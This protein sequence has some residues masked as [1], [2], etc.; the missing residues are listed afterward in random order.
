MQIKVVD[1]DNKMKVPAELIEISDKTLAIK[2]PYNQSIL[3][4]IKGLEGRKWDKE[5]KMWSFMH[6]NISQRNQF[7]LSVMTMG[8]L[9]PELYNRYFAPEPVWELT[10]DLPL[11]AHQVKMVKHVLRYRRCGL[12]AEMGTGKTLAIIQAMLL[13]A[14]TSGLKVTPS[15][16][17]VVGPLVA[18]RAWRQEIKKWG[19]QNEFTPQLIHSHH[20]DLERALT[21]AKY[22]PLFVNIDESSRI[23]TP[24]AKRT[25]LVRE[26]S[27]LSWL[28]WKNQ[29]YFVP[30]TG[31]VAPKDP[32]DWYMQ[33]EIARPGWYQENTIHG[34]RERLANMS[35]FE[36]PHGNYKKVDS[37]KRSEVEA[38][39]KRTKIFLVVLKKD[40]LDLPEKVYR[41]II[42][43]VTPEYKRVA[44][45][46]K[47]SGERAITVLQQLRQLSDGFQYTESG[48]DLMPKN[49]KLDALMEF[50]DEYEDQEK[51][52]LVVYSGYTA[53]VDLLRH[54]YTKRGWHVIQVDGRGWNAYSANGSDFKLQATLDQFQS[55]NLDEKICFIANADAGG[56]GI[57]LTQSDTIV[58]Y[59]NSF[60]AESRI[61]SEDRIHRIGMKGANIVDLFHLPTD[62]QVWKLLKLKRSLQSLTL[63]EI[64]DI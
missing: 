8:Q 40:C 30:M 20:V 27:R 24:G 53:S 16:F 10:C 39:E 13:V 50:M 43:P 12:P 37:W 3:K 32:T 1:W 64:V 23:K 57:T 56:M 18:L 38:L 28:R 52:R 22:A 6:H 29:E 61:Q 44:Q 41:T 11:M 51:T 48:T 49:P 25:Q 54:A 17:W 4:D 5:T 63:G 15:D 47:T 31:T 33:V 21:E 55:E 36:G 26:V 58:Y 7:M 9:Y 19:L 46:I 14:Q 42:V 35:T 45:L 59:S 34:F 60:N 2:A 62:E